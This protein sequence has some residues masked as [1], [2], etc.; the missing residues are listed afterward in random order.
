MGELFVLIL[1]VI[2]A[3]ALFEIGII[4]VID[5]NIRYELPKKLP[6]YYGRLEN[7]SKDFFQENKTLSPRLK[8]LN[9]SI[10]KL[11][12]LSQEIENNNKP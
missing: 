6:I 4:Q 3:L 12:K 11:D 7:F 9:N 1:I 2:V 8:F 5:Y 10:D